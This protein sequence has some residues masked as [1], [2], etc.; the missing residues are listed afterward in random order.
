MISTPICA[1]DERVIP[2]P[3]EKVWQV[4][5]DISRYPDWYPHSLNLKLLTMTANG[6]GSELELRP[7]G[8][9]AFRCR[10]E[11]LEP[12]RRI[13]IRYP[14]DFIIGIGEW[15]LKAEMGGSRVFYELDVLANGLLAACLGKLLPLGKLHSKLM[16]E[17]LKN[18]EC[19]TKSRVGINREDQ[20]LT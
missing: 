16:Q 15:R 5:A 11:S 20:E 10:V 17:V 9:R 18:L 3:P 4:L 14:G 1:V 19:E 8:G 12:P 13:R 6:V 2:L 7:R